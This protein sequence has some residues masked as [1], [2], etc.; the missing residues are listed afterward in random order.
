MN[1]RSQFISKLYDVFKLLSIDHHLNFFDDEKMKIVVN[2]KTLFFLSN[3]ELMLPIASESFFENNNPLKDS[4]VENEDLKNLIRDLSN[5]KAIIGLNHI[6]FCYKCDSQVKERERIKNAVTRTDW[7]L[8]EMESNDDGL[9]LFV[10]NKDDWHDPLIELLPVEKT[11]DKWVNYWLP[12]IQIDIDTKLS[13][14]ELEERIKSAFKEKVIPFRSC[15]IDGV[16]YGVRARLGN[17]GGVNIVL[18]FATKERRIQY[19]R[20]HLLSKVL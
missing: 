2:E 6:G 17:V 16:V 18:D 8:Y 3:K 19:S 10:G 20:E 4:F 5:L 11:N 7:Q 15:V 9:W 1:L 12:H 13:H 14:K